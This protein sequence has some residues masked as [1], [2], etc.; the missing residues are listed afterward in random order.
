MAITFPTININIIF[1]HYASKIATIQ[2]PS[3]A[4]DI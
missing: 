2:F 3:I 1:D 4:F